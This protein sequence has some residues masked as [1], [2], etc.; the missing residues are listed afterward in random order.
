[1]ALVS[2]RERLKKVASKTDTKFGTFCP[3][4]VFSWW[5]IKLQLRLNFSYIFDRPATAVTTL[6]MA[7]FRKNVGPFNWGGRPYF[8]WKNWRPFLV[9]I[10]YQLSLLLKK[11]ATFFAHH[12]PFQSFVAHF[13]V[14]QK[15][16]RLLWGPFCGGPC[17]AEHAE[18]A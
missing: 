1:M 5:K 4:D 12:S 13:L 18:H 15:L 3:E 11:P 6:S 7:L 8:S 10:V 16:P 2:K 17:S 14:C 9:I